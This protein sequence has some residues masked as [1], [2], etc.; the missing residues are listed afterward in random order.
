MG[1]KNSGKKRKEF[2]VGNNGYGMQNK[3]GNR[4]TEFAGC[5]HV[6]VMN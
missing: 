4:L 1:Y 3:R 6:Y 5:E 2:S